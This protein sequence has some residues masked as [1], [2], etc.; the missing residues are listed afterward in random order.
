MR[1]IVVLGLLL[2]LKEI[3]LEKYLVRC[4]VYNKCSTNV[5]VDNVAAA[6]DTG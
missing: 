2:E 5:G 1:I 6:E 4:L 3:T